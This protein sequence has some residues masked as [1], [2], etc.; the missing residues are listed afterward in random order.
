MNGILLSFLY[1]IQVAVTF[2]ALVQLQNTVN[3]DLQSKVGTWWYSVLVAVFYYYNLF[4]IIVS[5]FLPCLAF[6][7]CSMI[8]LPARIVF[9]L[10]P[11]VLQNIQT[12]VGYAGFRT[13]PMWSILTLCVMDVLSVVQM[14]LTIFLAENRR[15]TSDMAHTTVGFTR[16]RDREGGSEIE[17]E[18]ENENKEKSES[19]VKEDDLNS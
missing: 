3:E 6:M 18:N 7:F 19:K 13:V 11:V 1:A 16:Q 17:N 14:F 8:S 5:I 12:A 4:V 10:P 9:F 15:R 2:Y